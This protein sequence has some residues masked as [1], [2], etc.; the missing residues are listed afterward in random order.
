MSVLRWGRGHIALAAG[1]VSLLALAGCGNGGSSGGGNADGEV[2]GEVRMLVNLTDNL[3]QSY[4]EDLVAPFEEATGVDV[5]IEGPTGASVAETFPQQLAAGNAPDVIQSIFPDDDTMPQLLDLSDLPWVEG[6]PMVDDYAIDGARYVVGIGSQTQS[7]VFYN[8]TAFEEAGITETPTTWD[9]FTEDLGRLKDAGYTPMQTAGQFE[10]GLQLQ[11]LFHPTLNTSH[12]QWQSAVADEEL[13]AGEAYLPMFQHYADWL[14]AGYIA[15]DDVGLDP[16]SADGNFI[17][18]QVGVYPQGS[19][20]VA[21]LEDA[22]ELPFEV[23]VFSPPVDAGQD[24]PGPQG[25]TMADPYMIN[26]ATGNMASAQ[27][28]VEYLVTDETAI[29]T[30]LSAD[31]VFRQDSGVQQ[32]PIGEQV[33][34]ILD[35]APELVAVGEGFGDTRLPVTGFNPKFTEIVQGL[36]TG[37]SPQQAADAL[38]DWIS[39]NR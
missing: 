23:G 39:E 36:Y 21:T 29:E 7:L 8:K 11:Q 16:S 17:G 12:P 38:D 1:T 22:G 14:D 19:W 9:E 25:A 4:W 18:G 10:T 27:A 37:Q 20:F 2:G 3:D 30:Q 24:Y 31:G 6:T 32:T 33:Q 35:E 34:Q 13:S 5:K 26:A 28:L 15:Q